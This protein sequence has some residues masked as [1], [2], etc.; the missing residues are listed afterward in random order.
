[1][2][3]KETSALSIHTIF[4]VES[5]HHSYPPLLEYS[6]GSDLVALSGSHGFEMSTLV[7]FINNIGNPT[8]P[9]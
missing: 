5:T 3:A 9:S 2:F 1:M 7:R 4:Y 6:N 8:T